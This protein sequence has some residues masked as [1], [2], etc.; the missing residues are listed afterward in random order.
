MDYMGEVLTVMTEMWLK[1]LVDLWR[2]RKVEGEKDEDMLRM[3]MEEFTLKDEDLIME[4][5]GGEEGLAMAKQMGQELEKNVNEKKRQL[6]GKSAGRGTKKRLD[7][8]R[9]M[10]PVK[11]SGEVGDMRR[12]PMKEYL[13]ERVQQSGRMG[14]GNVQEVKFRNVMGNQSPTRRSGYNGDLFPPYSLSTE[15]PNQNVRTQ[16]EGRLRAGRSP[17]RPFAMPSPTAEGQEKVQTKETEQK[18]DET[19][20]TTLLS[21]TVSPFEYPL[22]VKPNDGDDDDDDEKKKKDKKKDKERA[23]SHIPKSK[24]NPFLPR[25]PD[26]KEESKKEYEREKEEEE[27]SDDEEN[28]GSEYHDTEDQVGEEQKITEIKLP[29]GVYDPRTGGKKIMNTGDNTTQETSGGQDPKKTETKETKVKGGG[30]RRGKKGK[31][32]LKAGDGG[33]ED[34]EEDEE[35]KRKRE[36][37]EAKDQQYAADEEQLKESLRKVQEGRTQLWNELPE[38][39]KNMKAED[40][41]MAPKM[42]QRD[43]R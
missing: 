29:G 27:K 34:E 6:E 26:E 14:V 2:E 13:S 22:S 3:M 1:N 16:S 19:S 8:E 35:A 12:T 20:K 24:D 31:E 17:T 43:E 7:V 41:V 10:S 23:K 5:E 42:Q 32:G 36:E 40:K 28:D 15:S 33:S 37:I 21:L 18:T 25:K 39:G 9:M 38:S 30:G 4:E 11:K